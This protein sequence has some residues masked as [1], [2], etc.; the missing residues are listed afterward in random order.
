MSIRRSGMAEAPGV[1][2]SVRNPG[3]G[4]ADVSPMWRALGRE[5]AAI[6]ERLQPAADAFAE[7]QARQDFAAGRQHL[8]SVWLE[9]DNAYNNAME[10]LYGVQASLEI[11]TLV[12]TL[13]MEHP[14][15]G[16]M[17]AFDNA[18]RAAR[19][20]FIRK[21]NPQFAQ[22]AGALFDRAH[23][24]ARERIGQRRR[25]HA[26]EQLQQSGLARMAQMEAQL[27]GFTD[28]QSDEFRQ[29][30][31]EYEA[32]GD[33]LSA[34]PLSGFYAD[35]WTLR[36]DNTLSRLT[37]NAMQY[38]AEQIYEDGGANADSAE[39]A[40][41]VL[42]RGM[43]D[44]NLT[45]DEGQ[46]DAF[47]G[48]GRRRI[49]ARERERLAMIREVQANLRASRA[50]A[51][52]DARDTI[53]EMQ[54]RA[55]AFEVIPDTDMNELRQTVEA[56]QSGSLARQFN[57]LVIENDY[58]RSVQGA[59]L[60]QVEQFNDALQARVTAHGE[61]AG[62][63]AIA[64]R[65]G[66]AYAE[67][68]RR[69]DPLIVA[70]QHFGEAPPPVVDAEGR[71][72]LSNFG[73]RIRWA[74]SAASELAAAQPSYL[75]PGEREA[76]ASR[77][78]AGGEEGFA[79][80]RALVT[81]AFAEEGDGF[82]RAQRMLNEVS[83]RD[84]GG[85]LLATGTTLLLGGE[86]SSGTARHIMEA[87][88]LRQIDGYVRPS[89]PGQNE[90]D[91]RET[92]IDEYLGANGA[93]LS[94]DMRAQLR[95][96]TDLVFEGMVAEGGEAN[97]TTY[98]AAV[99]ASLGSVTRDVNGTRHRFGGVATDRGQ[100][101]VVIPNWIRNDQFRTIRDALTA[102]DY[103]FAGAGRVPSVGELRDWKNAYLVWTGEPGRYYL[104]DEP[105]GRR[106]Y[107]FAPGEPYVLDFN[108]IRGTLSERRPDAVV[109]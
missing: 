51:R 92:L 34:N 94:A 15:D 37:A 71:L 29:R 72:T 65:A 95:R 7:A 106:H 52:D 64:L 91:R 33:A 74:E 18:I 54:A 108:L 104:A 24:S 25:N 44:P 4:V 101:R 12:D 75:S 102:R 16:D 20:E 22:Q 35:E 10:Q 88:R 86:S 42:E 8:R 30:W 103:A 6:Q 70:Q 11:D 78:R 21:G 105:D 63:A 59:S 90:T 17:G 73:P 87:Q 76:I 55:Q 100:E 27:S 45:L 99:R 40:L 66:R 82:R 19:T 58:R 14:I 36:R 48:E 32:T 49:M 68:L 81:A 85:A 84:D 69:G 98:S 62:N 38:T 61:D 31:S 46:R 57:E 9:E 83:A 47:F 60:A 53:A 79:A 23:L 13:E 96:S 50:E 56:T 107:E 41:A 26:I 3:V 2:A 39:A 1:I 97:A 43:N 93:F 109:R 77:V 89:L 5:A 67:H 28:L 80:V